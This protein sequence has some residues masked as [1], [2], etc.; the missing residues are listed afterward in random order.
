MTEQRVRLSGDLPKIRG[1]RFLYPQAK[2]SSETSTV[3]PLPDYLR[4]HP[5]VFL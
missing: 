1:S 3:L 2:L 4:L 5:N